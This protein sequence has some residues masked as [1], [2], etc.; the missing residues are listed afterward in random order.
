MLSGTT[1]HQKQ[2]IMVPLAL[3]IQL[4][5]LERKASKPKL[6]NRPA[7]KRKLVHKVSHKKAELFQELVELNQN[8]DELI[9]KKK[10]M[11]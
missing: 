1:I 6:I 10:Q 11:K 7:P 9:N 2:N 5:S 4:L 8:L 3:K